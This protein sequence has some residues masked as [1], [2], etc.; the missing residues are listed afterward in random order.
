MPFLSPHNS[1]YSPYG[2]FCA[3]L[4][5]FTVSWQSTDVWTWPWNVR[6]HCIIDLKYERSSTVRV[7]QIAAML[8]SF[9]TCGCNWHSLPVS[10]SSIASSLCLY[11][12]ASQFKTWVENSD[13]ITTLVVLWLSGRK[14]HVWTGNV[15]CPLPQFYQDFIHYDLQLRFPKTSTYLSYTLFRRYVIRWDILQ[16]FP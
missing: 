13:K 5:S 4:N 3:M 2:H 9:R 10:P 6:G 14:A 7:R 1:S 12:K 16:I 11:R 15:Q 8:I